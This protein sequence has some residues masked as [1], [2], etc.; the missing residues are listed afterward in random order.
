MRSDLS[1]FLTDGL[2]V[3]NQLDATTE[4]NIHKCVIYKGNLISAAEWLCES[5][6]TL[7]K[8]QLENLIEMIVSPDKENLTLAETIII[9]K[10]EQWNSETTHLV[11]P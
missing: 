2:S 11:K 4:A 7:T 8:G 1:E 6:D 3:V 5:T 9:T 10:K